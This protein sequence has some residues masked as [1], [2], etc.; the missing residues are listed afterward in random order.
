MRVCERS[1]LHPH[2]RL[3]RHLFLVSILQ[4]LSKLDVTRLSATCSIWRSRSRADWIWRT[5]LAR[6]YPPFTFDHW[7]ELDTMVTGSDIEVKDRLH[8]LRLSEFRLNGLPLQWL[9]RSLPQLNESP[10]T[11]WPGYRGCRWPT[12]LTY[13]ATFP[14]EVR[15]NGK[16]QTTRL[17]PDV[18]ICSVAYLYEPCG[19]S[20][21]WPRWNIVHQEHE[22]NNDA[23]IPSNEISPMISHH[24]VQKPLYI[25]TDAITPV[26]VSSSPPPR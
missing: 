17:V 14:G 13:V 20:F 15:W 2:S 23:L 16:G 11:R 22:D 24:S 25:L 21:A 8:K 6:D 3:P 7:Q 19:A 4:Y 18:L 1:L 5:L 9:H 26:S 10:V 12:E